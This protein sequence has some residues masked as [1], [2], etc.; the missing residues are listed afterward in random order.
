MTTKPIKYTPEPNCANCGGAHYGSYH[1]PFAVPYD[2]DDSVGEKRG[3]QDTCGT[4]HKGPYVEI[5]NQ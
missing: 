1:C 2:A 4:V 3:L 5:K